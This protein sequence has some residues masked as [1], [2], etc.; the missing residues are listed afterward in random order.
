MSPPPSFRLGRHPSRGRG[1]ATAA[2]AAT[3]TTAAATAT[4]T[5]PVGSTS[6]GASTPTAQTM[7]MAMGLAASL[8][9][10]ALGAPPAT[11]HNPDRGLMSPGTMMGAM[12]ASPMRPPAARATAAAPTTT[13]TTSPV[14]NPVPSSLAATTTTAAAASAT[15]VTAPTATTAAAATPQRAMPEAVALTPLG[16]LSPNTAANLVMSGAGGSPFT[17]GLNLPPV[18]SVASAPLAAS[19]S[20][21]P[22]TNA[23]N[24][25]SR[26]GLT[27]PG[28]TPSTLAKEAAPSTPPQAVSSTPT[29]NAVGGSA[30]PG[31]TNLVGAAG[32]SDSVDVRDTK[33]AAAAAAAAD[34]MLGS[35]NLM[36]ALTSLLSPVGRRGGGAAG[37]VGS[38]GRDS[39]GSGQRLSGS[40]FSPGLLNNT[41]ASPA[42][43][44]AASG[45]ASVGPVASPEDTV[46]PAPTLHRQ[47]PA[48]SAA[49]RDTAS[50]DMDDRRGIRMDLE[51]IPAPAILASGNNSSSEKLAALRHPHTA[52][53][54]G[55]SPEVNGLSRVPL[56]LLSGADKNGKDTVVKTRGGRHRSLR[57][58]VPPASAVM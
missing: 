35:P 44:S 39:V 4:A 29:Y 12:F 46:T 16:L 2:A 49:M 47:P 21:T 31:T 27:A 28:T 24:V 3:T 10:P 53:P 25:A 54:A 45:A 36:L 56:A 41:A 15:P 20:V 32:G 58:V 8:S 18:I 51:P 17:T 9:S 30:L 42:M 48:G 7:H 5:A 19:L 33:A 11:M 43:L 50:P 6:K 13:T 52:R 22:P 55:V 34:K 26:A 37:G 1:T 23:S 57:R 14:T 40:L 38:T